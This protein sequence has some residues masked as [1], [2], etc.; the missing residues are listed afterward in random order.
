M[1]FFLILSIS[2]IVN[3][4]ANLGFESPAVEQVS[5]MDK[6]VASK[7]NKE[8]ASTNNQ[9][10]KVVDRGSLQWT[11][12]YRPKVPNEIVGNQSMVRSYAFWLCWSCTCMN[13]SVMYRLNNFMIG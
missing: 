13:I 3:A 11:E 6:S 8:I 12:K 9:K 1:N 4:Y 10:A 5:T 7:T 2:H